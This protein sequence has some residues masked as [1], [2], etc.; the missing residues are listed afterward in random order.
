MFLHHNLVSVDWLY[1]EQAGG[2]KFVHVTHALYMFK[3]LTHV[4]QTSVV[5]L[6]LLL[7]HFSRV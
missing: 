3:E 1:Q 2:P 7:S 6:L 5:T 4:L